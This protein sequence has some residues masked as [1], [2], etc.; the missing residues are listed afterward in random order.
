MYSHEILNLLKIKRYVL[1]VSEY[2]N[3]LS[4]SP[5]I[6]RVEYNK[7]ND[8]YIIETDDNFKFEFLIK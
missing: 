4:T 5:Q 7:D 8:K 2:L 1:T 3:I 6:N